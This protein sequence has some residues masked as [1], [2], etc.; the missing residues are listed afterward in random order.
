MAMPVFARLDRAILRETVGPMLAVLGFALAM[1]VA[2][3]I[4]KIL[5]WLLE[6]QIPFLEVGKLFLWLIPG[7]LLYALPVAAW[8][9]WIVGYGRLGVDGELTALAS[10]AVPPGRVLRGALW[11][12]IALALLAVGVAQWG[13][14][15]GRARF[16]KE[17]GDLA[18]AAAL[19]ALRPGTTVELPGGLVLAVPK[20]ADEGE[21][22]LWL[23][24]D[25]DLVLGASS[26]RPATDGLMLELADGVAWT[27]GT[28]M[29]TVLAFE[30][31]R[32]E[33]LQPERGAARFG[34][35]EM[36]L[37]QL[38]NR[39]ADDL[40]ARVEFHQRLALA[41][42]LA[43]APLA[44]F[45][46]AP[47]RSRSGRSTAMLLALGGLLAYYGLFTLGKQFALQGKI[48]PAIG[49]WLADGV[50]LLAGLMVWWRRS[51]R[52]GLP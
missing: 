51:G 9:G 32:V 14:G 36:S 21:A 34:S 35:R 22:S 6:V 20:K 8:I 49:L 44:A 17:L 23:I 11:S 7:F 10:L 43:A 4:L 45:L 33:L 38:A 28:T 50:M 15:Q 47:R 5:P 25:R 24:R 13:A 39:P 2:N 42:G 27:R 3:R 19:Q 12:G 46:M 40:P 41:G 52:P 29:P 48:A 26:A 30:R 31:G 16:Q 37:R 1:L 18:R